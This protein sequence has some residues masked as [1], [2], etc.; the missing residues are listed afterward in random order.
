MENSDLDFLAAF[1]A[2]FQAWT[3]RSFGFES[4]SAAERGWLSLKAPAAAFQPPGLHVEA[5]GEEGHEDLGLLLGE[6]GQLDTR[7]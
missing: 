2:F 4:T 5:L 7:L 6:P 1:W 3:S